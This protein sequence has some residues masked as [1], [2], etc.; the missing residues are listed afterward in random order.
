MRRYSPGVPSTRT[1]SATSPSLPSE[2]VAV[3]QHDVAVDR[4]DD[5]LAV[6]LEVGLRVVAQLLLDAL[7]LRAQRLEAVILGR[8]LEHLQR[9]PRVRLVGDLLV[10]HEGCEIGVVGV[11]DRKAAQVDLLPGVAARVVVAE[12]LDETQ[13]VERRRKTRDVLRLGA[14]VGHDASAVIDF[15]AGARRELRD[16]RVGND[17]H[18]ALLRV[19]VVHGLDAASR[20]DVVFGRGELEHRVVAQRARGLHEPLAVAPLADEHRAV[21]VLERPGDDLRRGGRIAV[22]QHREGH[23]REDRLRLGAVLLLLGAPPGRE[24]HG[25][26]G[27]EHREDLHGLLEDAAAVRAVVEDQPP[28]LA[29]AAQPLDGRAHLLVAT[30][31][32]VAVAD[33]ADAV[34]HP[35]GVG[36]PGDRDALAA[37][38]NGLLRAVEVLDGDLH[39][40]P[41][42]AL[43]Q[44]RDLLGRKAPGRFPVDRE[45]AVA[46]LQP[47]AVCRRA[48]IGLG[49]AHPVVLLADEGPHAAVLPRGE[50]LEVGHPLLGEE[51]R[52]GVQVA[53]HARGGPFQQ[54]VRVDRIDIAQR[55]L[56]HHI[57]RDLHRAAQ[58]EVVAAGENHRGGHQQRGGGDAPKAVFP[59]T[60]CHIAS[61]ECTNPGDRSRAPRRG[62]CPR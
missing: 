12:I 47:A 28:Q 3:A 59:V 7:E 60:P 31:G 35:S 26:L 52:V 61:C 56:T 24:H 43:E 40:A 17:A 62:G 15:A 44:C 39:A 25:T 23:L 30:L 27:H 57:D 4:L 42:L 45:D 48:F 41:R 49:D 19:R 13:G 53:D 6:G 11:G 21:E 29:F 2:L 5:L 33:V 54:A 9:P 37:Q 34:G 18:V 50:N 8:L 58:A 20:G 10:L 38:R 51:L 22:H 16:E 55:E 46:D 14:Q 32:E 1:A 36:Y